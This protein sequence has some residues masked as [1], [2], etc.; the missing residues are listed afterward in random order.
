MK[1]LLFGNW[2]LGG[3]V[4]EGLAADPRVEVIGVVTQYDPTS[5]DAFFN[6]VHET[7]THLGIPVFHDPA[8]LPENIVDAADLGLSVV[9]NR[10][11][12]S[13]LLSRLRILN[14]HPSALPDYR[15]RSPSLWQLRARVDRMGI[16]I[17]FV[18]E[19]IDTGPIYRQTSIPLKLDRTY[20]D[21]I[22]AFNDEASEWIV[23]TVASYRGEAGTPQPR[24]A[25]Y[26]PRLHLPRALHDAPLREVQKFLNRPRVCV[27]SGNRAEFGIIYPLL[28]ALARTYNVDLVISGGHTQAPWNT[29]D[30]VYA[31]IERDRLPVTVLEVDGRGIRDHYRDSFIENYRFGY[32]YFKRYSASYSVDLCVVLG[33]RVETYSFANAAFFNQVPI[34]HLFGGDIANVPYFDTNIR[35]AITKIANL[36]LASNRSSLENLTRLGEESWR[37]TLMGSPSLDNYVTGNVAGLQELREEYAIEDELTLLVTY[38]PSHFMDEQQN[39][40]AF[41]RVYDTAEGS[42]LQAVVTYPNNDDGHRMITEFLEKHPRQRG[43][44]RVVRNLGIRHYLGILQAVPCIALGN[45]SSGLFETAFTATP[46]INV[47]DR[48]SDRPRA[49][50]VIDVPLEQ[51]DTLPS[52]VADLAQNYDRIKEQNACSRF[53]FGEGRAVDIAISAIAEFL[54]LDRHQQIFKRFV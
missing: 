47:G 48:Q 27:F 42:G 17:H 14:V 45:S 46:A 8:E 16:T 50:N 30:E 24:S 37:C 10:L 13:I 5:P 39:F 36:H 51:L 26:Y 29:R 11:F 28:A 25:P 7:A 43:K 20:S 38:H 2:G 49:G 34:C 9:F 12:D 31:S 52:V 54:K 44:L 1:L 33:D 53:Y 41:R 3:K 4:L 40:Q 23:D 15:S 32:G 35:H 19:A 21:F 18:E 6:R 22:D